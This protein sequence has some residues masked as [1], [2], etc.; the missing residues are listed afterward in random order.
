MFTNLHTFLAIA[1]EAWANA[2]SSLQSHQRPKPDG[3]PGFVFSLDPEQR[4]FKNSLVA[5]VFAGVYLEALLHIE[6]TKALGAKYNDFWKYEENLEKL[7]AAAGL[8][9]A[10]RHFR[11]ARNAVMHEKAS[12]RGDLRIAQHE[13]RQAIAFV[14]QLAAWLGAPPQGV[15]PPNTR[16]TRRRQ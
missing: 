10:G 2:E 3:S 1:K 8:I 4:S 12:E 11:E 15:Q 13:A 14:E 6:G 16:C 7:G 9:E 5:I